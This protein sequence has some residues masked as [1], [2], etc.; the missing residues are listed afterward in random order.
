MLSR[1]E[2]NK[3]MVQLR[4][5]E[6]GRVIVATAGMISIPWDGSLVLGFL[7]GHSYMCYLHSY[8]Q[9]P[10]GVMNISL[11]HATFLPKESRPEFV[12]DYILEPSTG[13]QKA[14]KLISAN[15]S[16]IFPFVQVL[17]A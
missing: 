6:A 16:C 2:I 10:Q 9:G 3:R 17:S 4:F 15:S 13:D 14:K 5:T 7:Q 1:R 11:L 12:K 8:H